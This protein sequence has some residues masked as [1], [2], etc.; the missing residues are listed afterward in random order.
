MGTGFTRTA[1]SFGLHA[2]GLRPWFAR[3]G[4]VLLPDHIRKTVMFIGTKTGPRG[5]FV[6]RATAFLVSIVELDRRLGYLVTADHVVAKLIATG[7]ELW[8]R[9]NLKNGTATEVPIPA[10]A[11]W[12][13]PETKPRTDV[14]VCQINFSDD[15]D[16]YSVG[17]TGMHEAMA[18]TDDVVR[19][20][21]IGIGEEV[22][23]VGL[24]RNH[25][26]YERNVPIVR[27]GN[28]AAMRDEPVHTTEYG[29]IDAYL[30]EARSIGGLSGSPVFVNMPPYRV[31]EGNIVAGRGPQNY[32][33]GLMHGHFDVR[34][35]NDDTVMELADAGG[36]INTGIGV[37]VPV[38]KI[39]D[40]IL[41]PER[42]KAR[43]SLILEQ[44][45]KGSGA[46]PDV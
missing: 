9:V 10:D 18:A 36:S 8:L 12:F 41:E 3:R 38:S 26:G 46:T 34:N 15:E 22:A 2:D 19:A 28:I 39:L 45:Q 29:Y 42:V 11:W 21:H 32:L 35:L 14:V 37:V 16:V 23:I 1:L 31:I 44:R 24:F 7:Y 25:F 17:L 20:L 30:I 33:L 13:Y 27:I 43:Q 4:V 6:P 5:E 40:I